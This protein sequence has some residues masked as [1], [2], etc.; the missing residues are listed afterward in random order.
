MIKATL[1]KANFRL[2]PVYSFR[3]LIYYHHDRK[4]HRIQAD[5]ELEKELRVLHLDLTAART[6]GR[7]SKPTLTVMHFLQ[8][9]TYSNKVIPPNHVS[10]HGLTT[11]S[12]P[13]SSLI[14]VRNKQTTVCD[15]EE[16][17]HI[18]LKLM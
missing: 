16:Q 13:Q 5:M 8:G 17:M 3:G 10:C 9:H 14:F 7:A 4:Q 15:T 11:F 6:L 12:P 2:D 18:N 1:I